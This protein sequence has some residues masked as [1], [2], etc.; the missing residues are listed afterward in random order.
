[1]TATRFANWEQ[2]SHGVWCIPLATTP[3][4]YVQSDHAPRQNITTVTKRPFEPRLSCMYIYIYVHT[5]IYVHIYIY[6]YAHVC[7]YH[8]P[9]RHNYTVAEM[10]DSTPPRP[11]APPP[12]PP[13][14]MALRSWQ[15]LRQ[16]RHLLQ[17][18]QG[19][20]QGLPMVLCCSILAGCSFSWF[21]YGFF[22]CVLFLTTACCGVLCC[23]LW[24]HYGLLRCINT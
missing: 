23:V 14:P 19:L 10:S 12:R 1:M 24:F 8:A 22:C 15:W 4:P 17:P 6:I 16:R 11:H 13:R 20:R 5:H 18:G 2:T 21:G 9:N 3:L 7:S